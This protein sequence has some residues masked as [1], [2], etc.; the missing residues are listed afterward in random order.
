[1]KAILYRTSEVLVVS[2]IM[3]LDILFSAFSL[4]IAKSKCELHSR[5]SCHLLYSVVF[6]SSAGYCLEKWMVWMHGGSFFTA[7][8]YVCKHVELF[9]FFFMY[10]PGSCWLGKRSQWQ[11]CLF[12]G[13]VHLVNS[14]VRKIFFILK[15]IRCVFSN[16]ITPSLNNGVD[17]MAILVTALLSWDGSN[18]KGG[19]FILLTPTK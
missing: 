1:M 16:V 7:R 5:F 18:A 3:L 10:F 12:H 11:Y 6:H 15:Q 19:I 8:F 13:Q 14:K 9:S 2:V 17:K 4:L